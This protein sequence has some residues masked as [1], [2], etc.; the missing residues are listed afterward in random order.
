MHIE[1][2]S[3]KKLETHN[4]LEYECEAKRGRHVI[5]IHAKQ[6]GMDGII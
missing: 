3:K 5:T 6:V 1:S 2:V 4:V